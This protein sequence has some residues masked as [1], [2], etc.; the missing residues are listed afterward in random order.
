LASVGIPW[1]W[2]FTFRF[3]YSPFYEL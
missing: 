1:T 3:Y 2:P